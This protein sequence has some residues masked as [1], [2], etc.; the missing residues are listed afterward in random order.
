MR[1]PNAFISGKAAWAGKQST[2]APA[3]IRRGMP[4]MAR[5]SGDLVSGIGIV[6][7]QWNGELHNESQPVCPARNTHAGI[8]PP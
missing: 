3:S 6:A 7:E 8:L 2:D 5:T 1:M 4:S